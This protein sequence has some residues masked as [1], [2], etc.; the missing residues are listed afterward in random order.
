MADPRQ[1][2]G[3]LNMQ[4]VWKTIVRFT[5]ISTIDVASECFA[6][7]GTA[8]RPISVNGPGTWRNMRL[9]SCRSG[10][11]AVVERIT[12]TKPFLT[13]LEA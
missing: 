8:Q 6:S 4:S 1:T 13:S 10:F 3:S 7:I 5:G 2:T 12:F 9:A 11:G